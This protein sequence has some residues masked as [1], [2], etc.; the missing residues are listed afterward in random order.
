MKKQ[1]LLWALAAALLLAVA[2]LG[3][4][5]LLRREEQAVLDQP[6]LLDASAWL[7][8]D[9]AGSLAIKLSVLFGADTETVELYE[10]EL[11]RTDLRASFLGELEA[12]A[13]AGAVPASLSGLARDAEEFM[14]QPLCVLNLS[15]SML[16]E[17]YEFDFPR[18][19]LHAQM[20]RTTGK[21]LSLC[22]RGDPAQAE[23]ELL[24]APDAEE[25]VRRQGAA[26][27]AYL[28]LT[29]EKA[30]AVGR[31]ALEAFLRDLNR[32]DYLPSTTV[33]RMLLRDGQ[34]QEAVFCL[35]FTAEFESR[36]YSWQPGDWGA[37]S[38]LE[39]LLRDGR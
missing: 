18:E 26:W 25:T 8:E 4:W 38:A 3:P 39:E 14:V 16:F 20:D 31:E 10:E 22:F 28:G 1:T 35:W 13:Q 5:L 37:A 32:L 19:R 34:E 2:F 17:I 15:R 30:E 29:L 36:I 33:L 24:F 11:D 21:L 27:A 23:D 7:L 6:R 9:E 12:L